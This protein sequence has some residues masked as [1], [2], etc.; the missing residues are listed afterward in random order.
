VKNSALTD[1]AVC[2][3][4]GTAVAGA[5]AK[6]SIT[7]EM[8]L[9]AD[10]GVDSMGLMSLVFMLEEKTGIDVFSHVQEFISA[11]YVSDI[12]KIVQHS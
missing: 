4:I 1:E 3:L 12:I 10:L 5:G 2:R 11:E 9:R 7:P 8:S 6:S